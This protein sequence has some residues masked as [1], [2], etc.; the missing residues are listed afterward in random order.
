MSSEEGNVE[1]KCLEQIY[2]QTI[3]AKIAKDLKN[4]LNNKLTLRIKVNG[5]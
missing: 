1:W 3:L 5:Q 2:L 4:I